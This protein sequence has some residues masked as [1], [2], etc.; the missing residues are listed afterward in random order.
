M[1]PELIEVLEGPTPDFQPAPYLS[2]QMVYEGPVDA[3]AAFCE[4]RTANGDNIMERCRQAWRD[5]RPVKLDYPDE[6]RMRQQVDVVAAR[7]RNVPEGVVLMLWVRWPVDEEED[8]EV[9]EFDDGEDDGLNY[10]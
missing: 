3:E 1:E 6:L 5:L 9:E 8:G 10:F 4:L 7:L 2:M